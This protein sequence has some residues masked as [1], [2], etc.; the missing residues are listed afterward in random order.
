MASRDRRMVGYRVP[1]EWAALTDEQRGMGSL[2]GFK[3]GSRAGFL[4]EYGASAC[5]GCYVCM[6]EQRGPE[7]ERDEQEE[8]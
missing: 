6:G 2:A 1:T 5:G 4:A 8:E 7:G 3:R